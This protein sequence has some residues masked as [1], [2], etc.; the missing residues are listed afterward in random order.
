MIIDVIEIV[1]NKYDWKDYNFVKYLMSWLQQ[2]REWVR[3]T[4]VKC[5]D[6]LEAHL[7]AR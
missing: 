2:L 5:N 7:E 4:T 3:P 1:R 6:D